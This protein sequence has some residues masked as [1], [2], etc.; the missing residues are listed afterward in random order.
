MRT[1]CVGLLWLGLLAGG[2]CLGAGL[3]GDVLYPV[4]IV[5]TTTSDWTDIRLLDATLVI[6][7]W[8]VE[9]GAGAPDLKVTA[10]G[11]LAIS[12]TSYDA[13]PVTVRVRGYI[14]NPTGT[15]VQ[16]WIAKGAHRRRGRLVVLGAG[17]AA[18]V[19][20]FHASRDRR[21]ETRWTTRERS[22]S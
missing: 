5:V 11:A 10:S 16:I 1:L 3:P 22:L 6:E 4:E 21:R 17:E 14:A 7:S 2:A 20:P 12:K 19:R 15:S 9:Q 13:T 18:P 8:A